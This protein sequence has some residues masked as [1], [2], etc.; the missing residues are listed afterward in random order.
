MANKV[1]IGT[2]IKCGWE[3]F[4]ANMGLLI[5]VNLLA[6]LLILLTCGVLAG[7]MMAGVYLIIQRLLKKDAT[8]PV[9]GDIFKGFE[10]FLHTFLL[11]I[12]VGVISVVCNFIPVVNFVAGFILGAVASIG[13]MFV[14]FGKL[15]FSDALKKIASEI[16]TGPFW[17]LILTLIVAGL[18]GSV[19]GLLC[20]IGVLF[21]APIAM[22]IYVCA[23]HSAYEGESTASDQPPTP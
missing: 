22:C 19:G 18:I 2:E 14:V 21:T 16:S 3:I 10:Y 13:I 9:V 23:Y 8:V 15:S 1:E 20:G 17:M 5:L 11:V 7:P 12:V 4:K 6:G